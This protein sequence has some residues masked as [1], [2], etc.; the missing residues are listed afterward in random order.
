[1]LIFISVMMALWFYIEH[2]YPWE[3]LLKYLGQRVIA[4]NLLSNDSKKPLRQR[5]EV[6]KEGERAAERE[7]GKKENKYGKMVTT[8]TT[9]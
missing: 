1:M 8:G 2:S 7:K 9:I 5:E 3:I 6:G 4:C